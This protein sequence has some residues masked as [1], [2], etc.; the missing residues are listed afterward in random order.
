MQV[1][2]LLQV[3]PAGHATQTAPEAPHCV[4]DCCVTSMQVSPEQQPLQLAAVQFVGVRHWPA[5]QDW[6]TP[7]TAHTAPFAPHASG[8]FPASHT[9]LVFTQPVVRLELCVSQAPLALQT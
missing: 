2:P 6:P 8:A 5:V 9:P 3:S 7:H 4:A 1:P